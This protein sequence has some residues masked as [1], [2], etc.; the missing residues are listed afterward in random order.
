MEGQMCLHFY[1]ATS[2]EISNFWSAILAIDSTLTVDGR[3]VQGNI[4]LHPDICIFLSHY[5]KIEHYTFSIFKCGESICK[6]CKPVKLPIDVF[7][8]LKHIPLPT[9]G[10]DDH[11]IPFSDALKIS[12]SGKNIIHV[13]TCTQIMT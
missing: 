12:T 9:P 11:Y 5:C 6:L 7:K 13:C 2:E 4:A 3:Y 1:S 8:S 10:E